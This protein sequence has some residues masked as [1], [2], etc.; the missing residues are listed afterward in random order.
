MYGTF[1]TLAF[2]IMKYIFRQF[3]MEVIRVDV[4][5]A[6][7]G[8]G[9]VKTVGPHERFLDLAVL[10]ADGHEGVGRTHHMSDEGSRFQ[11]R[12]HGNVDELSRLVQADVKVAG[13]EHRVVDL[14]LGL[15]VRFERPVGAHIAEVEP[16]VVAEGVHVADT[17]DIELRIRSRDPREVVPTVELGVAKGVHDEDFHYDGLRRGAYTMAHSRAGVYGVGRTVGIV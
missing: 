5:R 7:G 15:H 17:H 12:G 11:G 9:L 6:L 8:E 10:V 1:R 3:K 13:D 2:E 16:L 4:E 14:L